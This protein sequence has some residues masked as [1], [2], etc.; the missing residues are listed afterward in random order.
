[1]YDKQ[2]EAMFAKYLLMIKKYCDN[3]ECSECA[4]GYDTANGGC[5]LGSNLDIIFMTEDNDTSEDKTIKKIANI[6][7]QYCY[8][9]SC[10][11][12]HLC[13]LNVYGSTCFLSDPRDWN[14]TKLFGDNYE[15]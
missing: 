2:D 9:R 3:H 15:K 12:C 4:I 1:M 6:L 11:N 5:K 14:T 7:R 10:R 13:E 8:G